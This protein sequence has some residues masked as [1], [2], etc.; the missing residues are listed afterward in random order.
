MAAPA[1]TA[2]SSRSNSRTV[3]IQRRYSEYP[4]R[5]TAIVVP[6]RELF[7]TQRRFLKYWLGVRHC[8]DRL[9]PPFKHRASQLN[10][11]LV[12]PR[13]TVMAFT[14]I[15]YLLTATLPA[16]AQATAGDIRVRITTSRVVEVPGVVRLEG[17]TTTGSIVSSDADTVTVTGLGDQVVT[18]SR[19]QRSFVGAI[20]E[21]SEQTVT[22]A[23]DRGPAVTIPRAA[24]ARLERRDGRR[25]RGRSAALGFLIG[26][27]GGAGVGFLIG[28]NCHPSGFLSCFLEPWGSTLG[29]VILGGAAGAV[30]GALIRPP[31][32]WKRV[33]LDWLDSQRPG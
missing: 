31:E 14:F 30:F 15:A 21:T 25:S 12:G 2:G 5:V 24:I 13:N 11:P 10:R 4:R 17:G 22:V 1:T 26:A 27:G 6:P 20:T 7:L 16:S 18:V 33:P 29:G 23:R 3:A 28:A 32:R 8:R 19:P 9:R